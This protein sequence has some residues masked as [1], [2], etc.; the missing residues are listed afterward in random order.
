MSS[1]SAVQADQRRCSDSRLCGVPDLP[2]GQL[3]SISSKA[4]H[5][6]RRELNVQDRVHRRRLECRELVGLSISRA[7]APAEWRPAGERRPGLPLRL[8]A[9]PQKDRTPVTGYIIRRILVMIPLLWAVATVTFFLM[10]AVPGGPFDREKPLPPA[11]QTALEQQVP[12]RWLHRA[13]IRVLPRQPRSRQPR[14]L[15]PPGPAR[16]VGAQSWRADDDAARHSAPS[17]L[18]SC[19]VSS[20]ASFRR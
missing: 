20:L 17:S 18:Q 8:I 11:T 13:P 19:L 2:P 12:P 6:L 1:A 15:I 16:H 7:L 9:V 4:T 14:A 5:R 3:S 10:H